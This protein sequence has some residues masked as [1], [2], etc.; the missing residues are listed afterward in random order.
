MLGNEVDLLINYPRPKRDIKQRGQEKTQEDRE[1]AR[2][3]DKEFFDGDRR[4]GYGGY[5]YNERFW[6]PVVPTFIDYYGLTNNSSILDVGSGKG[7]M[8]K[9]FN[10]ALPGANIRGIDISTYAIQHTIANMKPFVQVANATNLPFDDNQFD[11]V[12]S[13]NT[14]HNLD[15]DDLIIS[16]K[17]ITRVSKKNSFITVDAYN[18][19]QEKEAMLAWNL[20]AKTI[21]SVKEWK[22]LFEEVNYR[23]DFFWFIP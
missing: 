12:I 15:K 10:D 22:R 23:G 2:R 20:T 19:D 16:L 8:M 17:E 3:F 5:E 14:I 4:H 21:L 7:F 13:I 9:D 6:S 18:N 11:L 1:I